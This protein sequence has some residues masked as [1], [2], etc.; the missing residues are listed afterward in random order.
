MN[1]ILALAKRNC[2]CYFRD[3]ASVV[4]SLMGALIVI[5][6]YLIFLRNMLIDSFVSELPMGDRGAIGDLVDAWVLS[7]ILAIVP[8]LTSA[9]ALQ[10]MIRDR[11]DGRYRDSM[12]TSMTP[13]G[14]SAAYVLSTYAVGQIMSLVTFII[15]IAYLAAVGCCLSVSGIMLTLALTVPSSISGSI[16]VYALV[17]WIRSEGAFSGFFTVLSVLIG[18][19][20][21]IYMPIGT[22]GTAM[23][24]VS[25]LVP[26]TH[27]SALFRQTLAGEAFDRVMIGAPASQIAELR[28]DMGF[29]LKLF[30]TDFSPLMCWIF[31][32]IVT[33]VFFAIAVAVSRR[34]D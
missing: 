30:G 24:T 16:I 3:R 7:G 12:M 33:V 8:V 4:F 27:F 22:M 2:L 21:G 19:L 14:L 11:A 15:S 28:F 9:G 10:T 5:L 17:S 26:A 29:D 25:C 32:I 20:T 23:Q 6:L 18:F 34:K 13:A 1:D 31:I